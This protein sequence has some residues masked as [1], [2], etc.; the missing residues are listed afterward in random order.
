MSFRDW[1][2]RAGNESEVGKLPE[3]LDGLECHCC[4]RTIRTYEWVVRKT[5]LH[6]ATTHYAC[7]NSSEAQILTIGDLPWSHKPPEGWRPWE[8]FAHRYEDADNEILLQALHEHILHGMVV[9][10]HRG[11]IGHPY[12]R[13][14]TP[15][16]I[17]KQM[18]AL[19]REQAVER[20]KAL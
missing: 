13:A 2:Y 1:V 15:D 12:V 3:E 19:L 17:A 6:Y 9:S 10:P 8:V 7:S 14:V 18:N 20:L 4:H 16:R 11:G 5:Y